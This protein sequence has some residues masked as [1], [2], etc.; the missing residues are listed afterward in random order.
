M[1]ID[2]SCHMFRNFVKEHMF[3]VFLAKMVH[4]ICITHH[5]GP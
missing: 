3:K 1:E 2:H 4:K 5:F